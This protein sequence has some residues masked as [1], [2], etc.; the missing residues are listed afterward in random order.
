MKEF[1]FTDSDKLEFGEGSGVGEARDSEARDEC[2][3]G[4]REKTALFTALRKVK[5]EDIYTPNG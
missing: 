2:K 1:L 5:S 4:H 3:V